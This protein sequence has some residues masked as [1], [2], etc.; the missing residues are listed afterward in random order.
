M[1]QHRQGKRVGCLHHSIFCCVH[2][3][4]FGK[5]PTGDALEEIPRVG[6]TTATAAGDPTPKPNSLIGGTKAMSKVLAGVSVAAKLANLLQQMQSS[7]QSQKG[8]KGSPCSC[9][10][11]SKN[12]ERGD[13]RSGGGLLPEFWSSHREEDIEGKHEVKV[14][15]SWKVTDIFTWLQCFASCVSVCAQHTLSVILELMAFLAAIVRV[16]QDYA[17]LAWVRYDAAY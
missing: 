11:C 3:T 9:K 10:T 17:G 8:Y 14:R 13:H 15:R 16:S 12:P 4:G 2:Y 7:P 1:K 6:G 5:M